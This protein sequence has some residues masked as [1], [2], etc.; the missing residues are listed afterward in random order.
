MTQESEVEKTARFTR[1]LLKGM[2]VLILAIVIIVAS[3][4]G[5]GMY[6]AWHQQQYVQ[7]TVNSLFPTSTPNVTPTTYKILLYNSPFGSTY[8]GHFIGLMCVNFAPS[9][10]TV[11]SANFLYNGRLGNTYGSFAPTFVDQFGQPIS[12]VT[13][14]AQGS[15]WGN[16]FVAIIFPRGDGSPWVSGET[17]TITIQTSIAQGSIAVTLP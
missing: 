7:N 1:H 2:L 8:A 12:Q 9:D 4:V 16:G 10:I 11:S 13:M 5:I 14:Y 6:W 3:I 17:V 15:G